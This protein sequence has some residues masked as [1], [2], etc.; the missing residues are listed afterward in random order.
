MQAGGRRFDP[1]WLHQ[2]RPFADLSL[3]QIV[4]ETVLRSGNGTFQ[5]VLESDS[6]LKI[7]IVSQA[8]NESLRFIQ[9]D[10]LFVLA[11]YDAESL[12]DTDN[13]GLYGQVNKRIWW[14]PRR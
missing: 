7:R 6:S 13:L 1:A 9:N 12:F 3:V 8:L 11:P 4:A 2:K 10:V 5:G 14:M